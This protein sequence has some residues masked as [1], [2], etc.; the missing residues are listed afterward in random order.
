[1]LRGGYEQARFVLLLV[2]QIVSCVVTNQLNITIP[3]FSNA[4]SAM[5]LICLGQLINQKLKPKYDNVWIFLTSLLIIIQ[6]VALTGV[7]GL[8]NNDYRDVLQLD[9]VAL[10]ALYC[11]CFIAKKI[12]RNYVG[13]LLRRCGNDSFYIMGL[14]IV[15]FHVFTMALVWVGLFPA[16][17]LQKLMTPTTGNFLLL[18]LYTI[19]GIGVPLLIM[20]VIRKIKDIINKLDLSKLKA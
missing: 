8:N 20:Y 4:I 14:H 2:L 10:A 5:F 15:G 12:E 3:R 9:V 16:E 17:Q 1:M 7:V 6:S 13:K 11:I 19:F 18:L